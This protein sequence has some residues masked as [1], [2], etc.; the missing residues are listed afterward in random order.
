MLYY[1]RHKKEGVIIPL[2]G[3]GKEGLLHDP[4]SELRLGG[5]ARAVRGQS[6]NGMR[7]K[8][9]SCQKKN[10]IRVPGSLVCWRASFFFI[11]V[12]QGRQ[13]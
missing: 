2:W 13:V 9:K 11:K 12:I 6:M 3:G 5:S 8:K 10:N 1:S 4:G 7:G